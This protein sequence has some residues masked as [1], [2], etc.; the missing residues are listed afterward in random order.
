MPWGGVPQ[1]VEVEGVGILFRTSDCPKTCSRS[2]VPA[3]P[4]SHGL[5]QRR[6]SQRKGLRRMVAMS[7]EARVA[8]APPATRKK[9]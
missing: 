7:E 9:T 4:V 5:L 8:S 2:H 6:P 1:A 3:A